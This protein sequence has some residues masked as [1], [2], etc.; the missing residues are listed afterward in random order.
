[1]KASEI[2]QELGR[3]KVDGS[4]II[5]WWRKENDFVDYELVETFVATAEPNQEFAGYE[6]LDRAAMWEALRQVTP[7]HVSR[8]KRGGAE[9]IVWR[10]QLEDGAEKTEVCPFSTQNLL[11]IF[12][13]E[14]GGDVV[15][16]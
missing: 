2:R 4:C 11:A 16:Y 15:G 12:D 1:M 3:E 14:T 6:I 9:V 8:E 10:H 7:D 13:A 5:K